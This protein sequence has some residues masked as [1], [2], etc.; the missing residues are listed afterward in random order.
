MALIPHSVNGIPLIHIGAELN[1]ACHHIQASA[2]DSRVEYRGVREY[3][4]VRDQQIERL[5]FAVLRHRLQDAARVRDQKK[6]LVD[7]NAWADSW[8]EVGVCAELQ[9]VGDESWVV[10]YKALKVFR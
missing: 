4:T 9:E 8:A 3:S 7:A 5:E 10:G 1:Y 6:R 2:F